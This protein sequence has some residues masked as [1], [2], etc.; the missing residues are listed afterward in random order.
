M[1]TETTQQKDCTWVRPKLDC[2]PGQRPGIQS[3]V[4]TRPWIKSTG[5]RF[6]FELDFSCVSDDALTPHLTSPTRGE[7]LYI[8]GLRDNYPLPLDGGGLGWG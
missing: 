8:N 7:E 1:V 6:K 2:H 3:F 5:V 4:V